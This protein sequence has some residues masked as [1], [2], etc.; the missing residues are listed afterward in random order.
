MQTCMYETFEAESDAVVV[1]VEVVA[2]AVAAVEIEREAVAVLR[3][4]VP[5]IDCQMLSLTDVTAFEPL[6]NKDILRLITHCKHARR[7]D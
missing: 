5:A 2:V 4:E 6:K 1:A 3:V 7:N